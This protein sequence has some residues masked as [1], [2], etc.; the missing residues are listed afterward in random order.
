MATHWFLK[1][2]KVQHSVYKFC[3][4]TARSG[5][6]K[7]SVEV[8]PPAAGADGRSVCRKDRRRGGL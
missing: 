7:P 4:A 1:I 2:K 3:R 8:P 6:I 5:T